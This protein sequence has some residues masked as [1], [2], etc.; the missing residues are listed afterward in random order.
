MDWTV[1]LSRAER[2]VRV[3]IGILLSGLRYESDSA[4]NSRLIRLIHCALLSTIFFYNLPSV[5]A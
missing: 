5:N 4:I 3:G 1:L 2:F